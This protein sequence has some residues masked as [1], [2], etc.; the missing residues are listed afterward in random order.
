MATDRL[1]GIDFPRMRDYRLARTRAIMEKYNYG[2]LITWEAW[3]IRYFT[4]GYP[5]VP[6]RWAAAMFAMICR[7]GEPYLFAYTSFIPTKLRENMPWLVPDHV[8][9][10]I[11]GGKLAFKADNW[12]K[13]ID[14]V[15][16]IMA[17]HGVLGEVV[18]IDS[19]PAPLAV[20][21]GFARKGVKVE[22]AFTAFYEMRSVKN[23]DEIAGIRMACTIAEAAFADMKDAI[24]P[25]VRECELVG[26][27]TRRLYAL[28]ADET[29]PF[30]CASGPR[31]NPMHIDFTDR[32]IRPGDMVAIDVN[33]N[34]Y[35]GYKSCYYRTFMCGEA[36]QEHKDCYDVA[37]KM[38]YD[39]MGEIKA[40]VNSNDV[41]AKFPHDPKFWGYD[42]L[43]DCQ[44]FA[45]AHGLG[46][47]LHEAPNF[48]K[49][50][51]WMLEEGNVLAIETYY[52]PPGSDYGVRLEECVAVTK[53]GYE[54]LTH[55]PI[56]QLIECGI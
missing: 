56:D 29:M 51:G 7:G 25:G 8:Y 12:S 36:R 48:G 3:N 26:I 41:L 37:L 44:G 47:T 16:G 31:T 49:P 23:E 13:W 10:A 55:Y 1:Q 53:D 4:G 27:G 2:T 43:R 24:E 52:G 34:S 30:V 45:L 46:L 18:G 54:L 40:G 38:L 15:C 21:E 14:H 5:T 42:S 50:G 6:C 11:G 19:C 39:A 32:I 35:C 22:E 20:Q 28:G 9:T 17:E 33:A